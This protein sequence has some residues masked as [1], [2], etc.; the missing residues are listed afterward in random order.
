[1]PYTSNITRSDAEV[2]IPE[3]ETRDILQALPQGSSVL[4]LARRLPDM[5]RG[6]R[7]LPV[8]SVLPQVY[9]VGEAGRTPQTFDEI[10]QTAEAAWANKYLYA[11]EIA[12]IVPIPENV[13]EDADYDI[14]GELRPQIVASIGAKI[15]AALLF[16][17]S[18][19]EAPQNWPDGIV[20]GMPASHIVTLGDV[21]DLYDDI[22][23]EGCLLS[24]VEE[25]GFDANGHV[26]ALTLKA[27]LRGLRDGTTGLPIFK[28]TMQDATRWELD[29]QRIEFPKNGSYD[30][31]QALDITGDWDQLVYSIRKDITYKLLTEGV[32]T[33]NSSPR[34]IIHNLGQDDMVA[35]RVTF[36]MAW[37]LPNPLNRVNTNDATRY[38]FAALTP[39]GS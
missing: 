34:R 27:K 10:K 32:I 33:D 38:P 11:E 18:G 28:A 31:T 7:K 6:V 15:D 22:F 35:L 39:A 30:A 26:A 4:R 8:L 3:E 14:W 29:G 24:K 25:D 1:M 36:R 21:G 17:T 16:Y 13:L 9:F 37:Q 19:V 2:L 23:G 5:A 12:C 20:I